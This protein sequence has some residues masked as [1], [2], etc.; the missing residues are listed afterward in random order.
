MPNFWPV[1]GFLGL[2]TPISSGAET[3][4]VWQG[5]QCTTRSL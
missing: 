1:V 2:S 3:K 5:R 4:N